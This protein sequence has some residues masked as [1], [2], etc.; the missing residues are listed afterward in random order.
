MRM[1]HRLYVLCIYR[2]LIQQ[3][4]LVEFSCE[5]PTLY[6]LKRFTCYVVIGLCDQW[7]P[8]QQNLTISGDSAFHGL[9]IS[10]SYSSSTA[11]SELNVK[12]KHKPDSRH[13]GVHQLS[14][15]SLASHLNGSPLVYIGHITFCRHGSQI[16]V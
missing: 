11:S 14:R 5:L 16:F 8:Q 2:T 1:Q 15:G 6:L 13:K 10:Y 12:K 9:L 3:R 4:L 7:L